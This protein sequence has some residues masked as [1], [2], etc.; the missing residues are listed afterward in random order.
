LF[1]KNHHIAAFGAGE[2]FAYRLML[3]LHS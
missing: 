1:T 3:E 2:H